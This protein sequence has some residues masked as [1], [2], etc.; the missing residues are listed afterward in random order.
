MHFHTRNLARSRGFW[1]IAAATMLGALVTPL[2]VSAGDGGGRARAA[3][4][5]IGDPIQIGLRNRSTRETGL[6]ATGDGFSLR[7][8]NKQEGQGG[9]LVSGCR[10][11][12]G[13]EA[14]IYGDNLR[15]GQAFL[16]RVRRGSTG[17]RIEVD[18]PNARPFTTNATGVAEGLNADRVDSRNVGCPANT[19]ELAGLCFDEAARAAATAL[20]AADVCHT[21]GGRLPDTL[22]LRA[23]RG[24]SGIDLGDDAAGT[25]HLTDSVH[26][27]GGTTQ[28]MAVGDDGDVRAVPATEAHPYRCT[29][30][31]VRSS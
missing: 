9:G 21:A 7:F 27:D 25:D 23:I 30:E 5:Q 4:T 24:E 13:Q 18:G 31:L 16:F 26:S 29:F 1:A 15:D 2:A 28:V 8:S 10:A 19:R 17:G 12:A 22:A 6:I 11:A 14:C 20:A 3:G